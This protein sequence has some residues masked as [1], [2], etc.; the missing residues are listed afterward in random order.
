MD[1]LSRKE[2]NYTTHEK[3]KSYDII[4]TYIV[5]RNPM[6]PVWMSINAE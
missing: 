4:S 2:R 1:N 5:Q 6:S 3:S